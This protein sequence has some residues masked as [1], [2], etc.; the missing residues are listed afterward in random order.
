MATSTDNKEQQMSNTSDRSPYH[1]SF[2]DDQR[3]QPE[4]RKTSINLDDLSS[5]SRQGSSRGVIN[6][7]F[8]IEY[9][10]TI[11]KKKLTTDLLIVNDSFACIC[12]IVNDRDMSH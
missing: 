4:Q 1:V 9:S 7:L 5:A 8:K 2:N 6:K 10:S 11:R 12:L 3:P